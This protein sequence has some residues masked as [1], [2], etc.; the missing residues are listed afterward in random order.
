[1]AKQPKKVVLGDDYHKLIKA[2]YGDVLFDGTRLVEQEKET[3]RTGSPNVDVALGGGFQ[4]GT[5]VTL[6]GPSGCGKTT[7]ALSMCREWQKKGWK[8][9][10]FPTEHRMSKRDFDGCK[11]LDP[12]TVDVIQSTE[13][14]ILSAQDVFSIADQILRSQSRT[15]VLFDSFSMLAD[16]DDMSSSDYK[17]GRPAPINILVGKFVKNM[18]PILPLNQNTLI[19]IFHTYANINGYTSHKSSIPSKVEFFRSTGLEC[20]FVKKIVEGTGDDEE[21]VGQSV[22]WKVLR[23]MLSGKTGATGANIQIYGRGVETGREI[24]IPAK[25]IG[26]VDKNGSWYSLSFKMPDGKAISVKKQGEKA[27]A[28]YFDENPDVLE[29]LYARVLDVLT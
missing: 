3:V 16:A 25:T 23:T 10:I 20:S 8:V 26:V 9:V 22:E 24:L 14:K 21:Q 13:S 29:A 6:S 28:E 1:M 27:M 5:S 7:L 15:L 19:G 2:D 11:G 18:T 17:Q 4:T 12:A